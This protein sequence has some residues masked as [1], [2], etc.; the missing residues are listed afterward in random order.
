MIFRNYD[1]SR[2]A[3]GQIQ[4]YR[5]ARNYET[6]PHDDSDDARAATQLA[7][8]TFATVEKHGATLYFNKND[9]DATRRTEYTTTLSWDPQIAARLT[10]MGG[11]IAGDTPRLGGDNMLSAA[12]L[13]LHEF[14]HAGIPFSTWRDYRNTPD[15]QF[16]NRGERFVEMG[17][18]HRFA[19]AL[20]EGIR[21]DH[22]GD[23][24]RVQSVTTHTQNGP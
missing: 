11:E 18:E 8:N 12:T 13:L 6:T 2:V 16:E 7:V 10:T 1:G 23:P 20:G 14:G 5:D 17:V 3:D 4:N 24:V 22:W 19:R 9:I 21:Y 15:A